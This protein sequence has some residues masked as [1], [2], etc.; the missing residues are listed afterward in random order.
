MD[1]KTRTDLSD[2]IEFTHRSETSNVQLAGLY[3]K[4]TIESDGFEGKSG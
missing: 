4:M 3:K 1:R 2:S